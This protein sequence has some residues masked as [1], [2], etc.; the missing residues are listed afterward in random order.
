MGID[1]SFHR[2]KRRIDLGSRYKKE[3][4]SFTRCLSEL[5]IKFISTNLTY[6]F[7]QLYSFTYTLV[8]CRYLSGQLSNLFDVCRQSD[9]FL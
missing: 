4:A 2:A 8:F 6:K 3:Q 5:R 7:I 1:S 9:L